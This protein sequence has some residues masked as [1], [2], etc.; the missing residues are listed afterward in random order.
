MNLYEMKE[1]YLHILDILTESDVS[2]Q[3][4]CDTLSSYEDDIKEKSLNIG[5]YIKNLEVK[6]NSMKL[7]IATI[8][9]KEKKLSQKIENFKKY[10]L[11]NIT[12]L[13]MTKIEGDLF[14][15]NIRTNPPSVHI[16]DESKIPDAF[17]H[18]ETIIKIDKKAILQ[19]L[20]TAPNGKTNYAE[21]VQKTRIEIK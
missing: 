20:K 15:I 8:A 2:E 5:A 1:E 17:K 12:E 7:H 18:S 4:I 3:E 13:G 16:I 9:E 19:D 21:I 11:T 10:L 14:D 6:C